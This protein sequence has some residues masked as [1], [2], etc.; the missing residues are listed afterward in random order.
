MEKVF[1]NFSTQTFD[2]II[3]FYITIIIIIPL[4][5]PRWNVVKVRLFKYLF[6]CRLLNHKPCVYTSYTNPEHKNLCVPPNNRTAAETFVFVE[7]RSEYIVVV[8]HI[9]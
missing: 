4:T 2:I 9:S 1:P 7:P 6:F 3:L 8:V 5:P